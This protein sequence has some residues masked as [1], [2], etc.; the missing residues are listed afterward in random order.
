[1]DMHKPTVGFLGIEGKFAK[2]SND[3]GI[4]KYMYEVSKRL[5]QKSEIEFKKIEVKRLHIYPLSNFPLLNDW[6]SFGIG[7]LHGFGSFNILHNPDPTGQPVFNKGNPILVSTI[8]DIR[9]FSIRK[10]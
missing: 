4:R 5:A 6:I 3:S 8:H 2:E 9:E 7:S 1:M 10:L